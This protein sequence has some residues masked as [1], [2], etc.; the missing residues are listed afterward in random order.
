MVQRKRNAIGCWICSAKVW[1]GYGNATTRTQRNASRFC[2]KRQQRETG[3]TQAK[4]VVDHAHNRTRTRRE[5]INCRSGALIPFLCARMTG[6]R[7]IKGAEHFLPNGW[8][9]NGLRLSW[10]AMFQREKMNLINMQPVSKGEWNR[11]QKAARNRRALV[12]LSIN[13]AREQSQTRHSIKSGSYLS[14]TGT[15]SLSALS[16][17]PCGQSTVTMAR[18]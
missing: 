13:R 4:W 9:T 2:H 6:A 11:S 5:C 17:P 10:N 3:A 7:E 12:A 1:H 14:T 18:F 16:H 8:T 15:L